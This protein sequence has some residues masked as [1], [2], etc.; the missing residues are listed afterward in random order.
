MNKFLK[1]QKTLISVF[2]LALMGTSDVQAINSIDKQANI[3]P[4][5]SH[6][7]S[8]LDGY[9]PKTAQNHELSPRPIAQTAARSG[10]DFG[11]LYGRFYENA[12]IDSPLTVQAYRF[13]DVRSQALHD[14]G[15]AVSADRLSTLIPFHPDAGASKILSENVATDGNSE[16]SPVPLPAAAWSF[17]LGLMGILGLKKRKSPPSE[18]S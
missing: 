4:G 16:A 10:V 2:G 18:T 7:L 15:L 1:N 3:R 14:G 8:S 11:I 13:G 12:S 17:L 6:I 5:I 9:K